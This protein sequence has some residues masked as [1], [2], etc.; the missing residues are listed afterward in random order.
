MYIGQT[1]EKEENNWEKERESILKKWLESEPGSV[2]RKMNANT[3]GSTLE[4]HTKW[5]Q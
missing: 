2:V 1:I 5:Q 3:H 4:I